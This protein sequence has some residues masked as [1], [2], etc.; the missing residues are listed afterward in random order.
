MNAE[1]VLFSGGFRR[2]KVAIELALP[3]AVDFGWIRLQGGYRC[4]RWPL[5]FLGQAHPTDASWS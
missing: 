5:L 3:D 2:L 4:H 1:G